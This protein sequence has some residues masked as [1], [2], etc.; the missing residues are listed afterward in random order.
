MYLGWSVSLVPRLEG[1][2]S[3]PG[4]VFFLA[5]EQVYL[6]A[7]YA[8]LHAAV[9][10]AFLALALTAR[11]RF[12]VFLALAL[13][14]RCFAATCYVR[15]FAFVFWRSSRPTLRLLMPHLPSS[16]NALVH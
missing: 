6:H 5:V 15:A 3:I 1:A 2:G 14:D 9:L 4:W 7:L 16:L 11:S 12:R 8:A 13:T 10:L